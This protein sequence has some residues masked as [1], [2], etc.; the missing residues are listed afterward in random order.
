MVDSFL[1]F[2]ESVYLCTIMIEKLEGIVLC[3]FKY[4]DKKN[5]VHIYTKQR[6]RMSFLIPAVRSKKS[7]VSQVLFQP[8]SLV[9]FEAEVKSK[10]SLHVIKEAKLWAPFVSIPY[11]PYKSGIALFLAEF[12][13]RALKEEADNAALYAYLVH[14]VRW[15]DSCDQ[16]FANFHLVFLMRLSRFLGLYPYVESYRPGDFFDLLNACFCPNQPLNC[17]FLVPQ[18]ALHIHNLM[19][20]RFDTMHMFT[21]N[22]IERNRCLEVIL[23]YY[24]L[25]LPDFPELKS[26]SVL[27]ELF[28]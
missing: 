23:S 14:S 13:F 24:R 21:M 26:L 20:M 1:F 11:D 19:R 22:R 18:E 12:L 25:H 15:L 27:K 3:S 16:S 5:I 7:T 6:G 8:M 17:A 9:E 28:V 2:A 4:N 10:S